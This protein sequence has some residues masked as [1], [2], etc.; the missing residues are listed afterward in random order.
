MPSAGKLSKNK[1]HTHEDFLM[2]KKPQCLIAKSTYL[3]SGVVN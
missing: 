2:W 3:F 1:C